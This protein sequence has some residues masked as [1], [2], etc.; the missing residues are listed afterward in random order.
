MSHNPND[1]ERHESCTEPC[2]GNCRGC[3]DLL[4]PVSACLQPLTVV[5]VNR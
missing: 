3:E 4:R 1:Y 5:R 2:K